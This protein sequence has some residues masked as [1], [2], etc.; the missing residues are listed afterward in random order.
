MCYIQFW[1]KTEQKLKIL[2]TT[3]D[4]SDSNNN[5]NNNNNH[6]LND[7]NVILRCQYTAWHKLISAFI[8]STIQHVHIYS[9]N[10]QHSNISSYSWKLT[11]THCLCTTVLHSSVTKPSYTF[12][13]LHKPNF[14]LY[15]LLQNLWTVTSLIKHTWGNMGQNVEANIWPHLT[16]ILLTWRIWWAPNNASKWQMGFNSTFKGVKAMKFSTDHW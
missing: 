15:I 8:C 9:D 11:N 7:L 13:C 12:P 5:N 14:T 10:K 2:Q 1:N 16:L 4:K 6:D 3:F